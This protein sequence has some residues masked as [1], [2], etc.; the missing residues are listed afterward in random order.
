MYSIG[1]VAKILDLST[2]TLRYY[3]KEKIIV[4]DRSELGDRIYHDSHLAWLRF[5]MKLKETQMPLAKIRE[6]AQ[7]FLEGEHTSQKR[8]KLLENHKSSIQAQIKNLME[9]DKMLEDKIASYKDFISNQKHSCN[10]S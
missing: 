7:L 4:P 2:H 1:E 9:T 5:V 8:L 10:E 6:Y 3:E